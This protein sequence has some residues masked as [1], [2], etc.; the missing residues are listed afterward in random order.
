MRWGFGS[1]APK[2]LAPIEGRKVDK[3]SVGAHVYT[4]PPV[5]MDMLKDPDVKYAKSKVRQAISD[6]ATAVDKLYEQW[7][8][9][10]DDVLR[11]YGRMQLALAGKENPDNTTLATAYVAFLKELNKQVPDHLS[12]FASSPM[13]INDPSP[14]QKQAL[15]PVEKYQPALQ[16]FPGVRRPQLARVSPGVRPNFDLSV[17]G[18]AP[19]HHGG[20]A[21]FTLTNMSLVAVI[22][23]AG[24]FSG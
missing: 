1:K 20:G 23:V 13:R 5:E 9:G 2:N 4:A 18:H 8:V 7:I 12:Q 14:F 24:I 22:I 11:A 6:D 10:T 3:F 21:A 19:G 16:E 17:V 15:P